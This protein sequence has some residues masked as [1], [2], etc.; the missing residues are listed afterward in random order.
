MSGDSI[1]P[2]APA[3]WLALA[4][5]VLF[6]TLGFSLLINADTAVL[7]LAVLGWPTWLAVVAGVAQLG[8]ALVAFVG[9]ASRVPAAILLASAGLRPGCVE[10][11]VPGFSRALTESG[12]QVAL[13]IVILVP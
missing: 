8:C 10:P 6:A 1:W 13:L 9:S 11:A 4:A 12:L 3:D 7:K 5:A 2:R